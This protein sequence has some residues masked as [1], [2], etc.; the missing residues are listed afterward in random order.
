MAARNKS[1]FTLVELL[2]VISIIGILVAMMIPA[3][4]AAREA[5]RRAQCSNNLKQLSLGMLNYNDAHGTFCPGSA[6]PMTPPWTD[7][8]S[9]GLPFGHFGWAAFLLPMVEEQS[10]FDTIDFT[11]PAYAEHVPEQSGWSP[12]GDRG[13]AGDP[14]NRDAANA[15]PKTF[16]CPSAMR[17]QPANMQK[18]YG[19]NAGTHNCCP[20]RNTNHDG[21]AWWKSGLRPEDIKDGTSHT[22]LFL[23][24][25]NGGNHSWVPYTAIGR[26]T[27]P[28]PM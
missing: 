6:G 15:Q 7:P 13:P 2:V 24:F 21:V 16:V 11:K 1:G 5:A 9:G 12:T 26:E 25:A 3:V 19:V 14:A 27:K 18:D 8:S 17:A 10:L 28:G 4:Q 20:E 22:F 23:E